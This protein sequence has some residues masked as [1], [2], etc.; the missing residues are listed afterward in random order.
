MYDNRMVI[1]FLKKCYIK[2][3][4]QC[5]ESVDI[6]KTMNTKKYNVFCKRMDEILGKYQINNTRCKRSNCSNS[7]SV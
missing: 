5:N 6:M 1:F 2:S 7:K 3:S 4:L